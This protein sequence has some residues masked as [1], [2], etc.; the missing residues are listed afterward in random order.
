MFS[1]QNFCCYE[2]LLSISRTGRSHSKSCIPWRYLL[3]IPW[4]LGKFPTIIPLIV[5]FSLFFL[6]K[7]AELKKWSY[8]PDQPSLPL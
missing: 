4:F 3:L 6:G 2:V 8:S 5:G 7:S 1:K